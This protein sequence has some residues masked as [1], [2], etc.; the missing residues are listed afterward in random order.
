[1]GVLRVEISD[2][3]EAVFRIELFRR[4]GAKKGALAEAVEE[5]LQMWTYR[6]IWVQDVLES[7]VKDFISSSEARDPELEY[8]IGPSVNGK[9]MYVGVYNR[10]RRDDPE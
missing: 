6:E 4:K 9:I 1:M 2:E 3:T 5:A 10:F 8:I 7:Q